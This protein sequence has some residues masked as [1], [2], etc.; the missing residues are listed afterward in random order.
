MES[1]SKERMRL[2]LT[3]Q[4][5]EKPTAEKLSLEKHGPEKLSPANYDL[6]L[7]A[8]R[9]PK[10]VKVCSASNQLHFATANFRRELVVSLTI[11]SVCDN[12]SKA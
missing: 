12:A 7:F 5:L 1:S 6:R 8:G 10:E 3:I 2:R 9:H 11:A 4:D